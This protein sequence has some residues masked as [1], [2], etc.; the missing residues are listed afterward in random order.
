MSPVFVFSPRSQMPTRTCAQAC[1]KIDHRSGPANV[2]SSTRFEWV[3]VVF[4]RWTRYCEEGSNSVFLRLY[5]VPKLPQLPSFSKLQSFYRGNPLAGTPSLFCCYWVIPERLEPLRSGPPRP[6][7]P[8]TVQLER[9]RHRHCLFLFSD[10]ESEDFLWNPNGVLSNW[11]LEISLYTSQTFYHIFEFQSLLQR[12]E[13]TLTFSY[14]S[15]QRPC[16]H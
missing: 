16:L 4:H 1:W 5:A 12:V 3:F 7:S 6:S 13:E 8:F 10:S 9:F 2:H 14:L 11:S 15:F